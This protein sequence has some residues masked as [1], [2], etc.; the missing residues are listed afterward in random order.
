MSA[1]VISFSMSTKISMRSPTAPMES[2]WSLWID[3]LNSGT[4][5][6]CSW[7]RVITSET[8]ST[9]MPIVR[10]AMLSTMTTVKLS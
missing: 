10:L 5:R 6:N 2:R 9:T 7:V 1:L 8:A 4:G 3:E